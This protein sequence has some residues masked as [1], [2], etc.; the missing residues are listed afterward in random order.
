VFEEKYG[1]TGQYTSGVFDSFKCWIV[2]SIPT[3]CS[4]F[5]EFGHDLRHNLRWIHN[6]GFYLAFRKLGSI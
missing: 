4:A 5:A 2:I 6:S 1:K 3:M